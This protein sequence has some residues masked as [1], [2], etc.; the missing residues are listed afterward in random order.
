MAYDINNLPD[1]YCPCDIC[2][3]DHSYE[4]D[5]EWSKQ[6]IISLHEEDSE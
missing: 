4:F 3:Y 6:E 2:G 1:D 5:Y